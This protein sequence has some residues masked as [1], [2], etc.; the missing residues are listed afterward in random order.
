MLTQACNPSARKVSDQ[1]FQ[2]PMKVPLPSPRPPSQRTRWVVPEVCTCMCPQV[3]THLSIYIPAYTHA[4]SHTHQAEN[5][6]EEMQLSMLRPL[7]ALAG[8]VT[9]CG[10]TAS[11]AWLSDVPIH[12]DLPDNGLNSVLSVCQPS[13]SLD[14]N[15]PCHDLPV[16]RGT[17]PVAE[18]F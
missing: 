10:V 7:C 14:L 16:P 18:P 8:S 3:Y 17:S 5:E 15:L 2:I 11:G 9:P 13:P 4:H 1:L 12:G 6:A